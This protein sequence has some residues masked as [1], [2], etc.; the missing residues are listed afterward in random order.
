MVAHLKRIQ[1]VS[2][3]VQ[4]LAPLSGLRIQ[5]CRELC[6]RSQTWL[7]SCVA[8][9][10]AQ[11]SGYSSDLTPCLGNAICPG[12]GPKKAKKKKKKKKKK[13]NGVMTLPAGCCQD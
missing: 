1:L 6:C 12:C 4:S 2:M 11:A 7:G 13:R 8:V 10:L 3:W 5:H 9:A